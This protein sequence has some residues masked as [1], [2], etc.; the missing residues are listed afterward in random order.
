MLTT[1]VSLDILAQLEPAGFTTQ[2]PGY[3]PALQV[4]V[5]T[6]GIDTVS[7]GSQD[8]V[9]SYTAVGEKFTEMAQIKDELKNGDLSKEE[10]EAKKELL[11]TTFK[12]MKSIVKEANS[13]TN[14][15]QKLFTQQ[16]SHSPMSIFEQ[17]ATVDI[18]GGAEEILKEALSSEED[19]PKR[20]FVGYVGAK[21]D[22]KFLELMAEHDKEMQEINDAREKAEERKALIEAS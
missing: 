9:N 8:L 15:F 3:N 10:K 14:P 19:G 17:H 4:P 7:I 18:L 5:L 6:G 21:V 11:K 16:R 12:E 2:Q 22:Q 1:S 13:Y 20:A